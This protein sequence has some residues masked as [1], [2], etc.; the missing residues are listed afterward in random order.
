MTQ[1]SPYRRLRRQ[2]DHIVNKEPVELTEEEKLDL[3]RLTHEL[4]LARTELEVQN[5]ELRRA[6]RN[7]EA[8]SSEFYELYESAPMWP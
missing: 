8:V 1:D 4:E 7:L 5:E 2:A 3:L 6:A